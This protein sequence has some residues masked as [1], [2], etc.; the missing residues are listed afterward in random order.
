MNL[1]L[2]SAGAAAFGLILAMYFEAGRPAVAAAQPTTPPVSMPTPAAS[3]ASL[4]Y[5]AYGTP[6]PDM[7]E[8]VPAPGVPSTLTLTQATD[9]AVIKSP[10]FAIARAQYDAIR[11]KYGAARSAL[12]PSVTGVGAATRTYG[13]TPASGSGGPGKQLSASLQLQQLIFDGG[14]AIAGIKSAHEGSIAG[15]ATLLR[16]LQTLAFN[17]AKAYYAA[18]QAHQTTQADSQLVKQAEVNQSLVHAKIRAGAAARSDEA[19]AI[20]QTAQARAKLV[21]AQGAE[22]SAD[23]FFANTM[24]LDAN[25]LVRPYNDTPIDPTVSLLR[26]PLLTYLS[27]EKRALLLRPDYISAVH[28]AAAAKA[29]VRFAKLAKFP[30]V[31]ATATTGTATTQSDATHFLATSSLGAKLNFPLFDQG[32]TNFNVATAVSE[33]DI[34]EATLQESYLGVQLDVR[35]ALAGLISAQAAVTQAQAE[36]TSAQVGL[37]AA[38]ARYRAGVA[39][40]LDLVTAQANL[41]TAQTDVVNAVSNLRIAEQTYEYDLGENSVRL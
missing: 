20:F 8:K 15:E 29:N 10:V 38:Q 17:V 11:A 1:R 27:A 16:S 14:R 5:P 37:N 33:S 19:T 12:L 26:V 28:G 39:T 4:P 31:N 24:G 9:I 6:R 34:A 32:L 25:T 2:V 30:T 13:S 22:I 7:L 40:L 21:Q 18:L 35:Q 41:S 3:E 36:L 23:A